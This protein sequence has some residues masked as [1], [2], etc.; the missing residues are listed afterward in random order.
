MKL[1]SES[2]LKP[3]LKVLQEVRDFRLWIEDMHPI[4]FYFLRFYIARKLGELQSKLRA[5]DPKS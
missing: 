3:E 2:G 4:K 1:T 5:F